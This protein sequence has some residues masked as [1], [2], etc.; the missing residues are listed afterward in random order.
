MEG[1]RVA[2]PKLALQAS[3]AGPKL[4]PC[5]PTLARPDPGSSGKVAGPKLALCMSAAGPKLA[6]CCPLLARP[7]PGPQ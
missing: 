1:G 2:G 4:P 5:W 3:A 6:P 7:E